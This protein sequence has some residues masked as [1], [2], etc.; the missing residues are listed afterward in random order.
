MTI[1]LFALLL[2]GI[3]GALA[4]FVALWLGI[5]ILAVAF[6]AL[7]TAIFWSGTRADSLPSEDLP[8]MMAHLRGPGI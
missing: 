2:M 3:V 7:V 5:A 6:I 1:G 8:E 4:L